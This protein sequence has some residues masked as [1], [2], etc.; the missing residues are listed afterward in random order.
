M[1]YWLEKVASVEP[2]ENSTWNI[3]PTFSFD[4]NYLYSASIAR[5][6]TNTNI[7]CYKKVMY[8]TF[9]FKFGSKIKINR[10][11]KGSCK[12][13]PCLVFGKLKVEC[14]Y[15]ICSIMNLRFNQNKWF[16][17]YNNIDSIRNLT[18]YAYLNCYD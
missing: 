12:I 13:T 17:P 18:R 15:S 11:T 4:G 7:F 8:I 16:S 6:E 14:N 9:K 3:F 10:H 1:F 2:Y 5:T